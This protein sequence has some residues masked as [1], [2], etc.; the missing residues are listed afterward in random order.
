METTEELWLEDDD[1]DDFNV[2][3]RMNALFHTFIEDFSLSVDAR[4]G[5]AMTDKLLLTKPSALKRQGL[6]SGEAEALSLY[7]AGHEGAHMLYSDLGQAMESVIGICMKKDMDYLKFSEL[8]QIV[9]DARVDGMIM[10][11]RPGFIDLKTEGAKAL[12]RCLCSRSPNKE[13]AELKCVAAG[14]YG[15]DFRKTDPEAWKHVDCVKVDSVSSFIKDNIGKIE[16]SGEAVFMAYEAYREM[17]GE[18]VESI[19]EQSEDVIGGRPGGLKK[20]E[21]K[22]AAS[23]KIVERME[24][25]GLTEMMDGKK[26]RE[27]REDMEAARRRSAKAKKSHLRAKSIGD[28]RS[29]I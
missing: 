9:E 23:E 26:A 28:M 21:E 5:G 1:P 15:V 17:Y 29:Q 4:Q 6:T 10:K 13:K 3:E 24:R 27:M 14:L 12:M 2:R 8:I 16:G 7:A 22:R 20:G 25:P 18:P 11:D 19:V